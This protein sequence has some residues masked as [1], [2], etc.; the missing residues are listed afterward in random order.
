MAW[1][2]IGLWAASVAFRA[3]FAADP[4]PAAAP[5]FWHPDDLAPLSERFNQTSELL[6]KPFGERSTTAERAA[7]GLRQYREALDLLGAAAPEAEW[8][9]LDTLEREYQRQH[10]ALQAFA[11]QVITDYDAVFTAA[12]DRAVAA[13]TAKG[14]VI[15]QCV[16]E[17]RQG[18]QLPGVPAKS[19]PNPECEGANLNA[20]LAAVVD[21]DTALQ[22]ALAEILD[23]P[24]PLLALDAAPQPVNAIGS[25]ASAKRW[26]SI[27]DLMVAGAR[28][29]LAAIERRD[30]D[31][32]TRIEAAIE[33]GASVEQ[34]RALEPE[35]K[36]IENETRAARTAAAAPVI[37][38]AQAVVRVKW[39]TEPSTGWCANPVLFGGCVGE[40]ATRSLVSRLL[41]E[42]K[43]SKAFPA[44]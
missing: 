34:L 19:S 10:A 37:A 27:R 22:A 42:K 33:Q 1:T 8:D 21:A 4:A 12:V 5:G 28:A 26:L 31:A 16:A 13:R 18:V 11:E 23:R 15:T 25:G 41:A 43:V 40:D 20:E 29:P 2:Q 24:W 9:R 32:R 39:G 38:A 14:G 36:R 3:A 17:V 44:E 35:A 6:Q 30:D 7:A